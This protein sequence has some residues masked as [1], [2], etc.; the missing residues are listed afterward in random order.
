MMQADSVTLDELVE[1][2]RENEKY[3]AIDLQLIR[4]LGATELQKR[5]SLKEAVK[6]TRNKLHQV[7]SSYQEKPIPY[8]AWQ[9][10]LSALPAELASESVRAGLC[11][12]MQM[13]ASTQER[14]AIHETF[15]KQS[16]SGLGPI[17]SILDL[18][19]GLN[20]LNLPWM[21]FASDFSY[22][23]CDIYTDMVAFL[24]T[25]FAHFHLHGSA[26]TCDLTRTIP[27]QP[28]Q[29]A[30]L[31]KTIPCLEQI[32]KGAGLR[33]L[34]GLQAEN[35]LVT[36]PTHSLGGRSK[37]MVHNYSDHFAQLVSGK[38]WQ[39]T[40]FDFPGELAFLIRK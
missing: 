34:E 16:L 19:C 36:F 10:E 12:W 18:A 35:I 33:L 17:H 7:G 15:F 25:F 38:P 29:L 22:S 27:P 1:Q 26:F 40:R 21:P 11:R 20:P 8:P 32:D 13:H 30:L 37:G 9:N 5:G 6:S 28:V 24:D 39:I 3:T 31:L 14:L 23:A 4:S 2:V